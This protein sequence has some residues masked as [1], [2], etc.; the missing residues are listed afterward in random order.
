MKRFKLIAFIAFVAI[1]AFMMA[2]CSNG[3]ADNSTAGIPS[4]LRNT[5]WTKQIGASTAT[6]AFETDDLVVSGTNTSYDG[7]CR[8]G[9]YGR[10]C[11]GFKNN[12]GTELDF[13]YTCVGNTL[14]IRNCNNPSFNGEWTRKY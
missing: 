8:Y 4:E 5:A 10:G 6:L 11:C 2:G 1:S 9:S 3:T 13:D 14:T 12:N 7:R